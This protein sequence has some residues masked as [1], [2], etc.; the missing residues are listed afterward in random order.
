MAERDEFGAF[1]VGFVVGTLTG[2]VTALLLAPQ[3]GEETRGVIRDKA[4]ELKSKAGSTVEDAYS[5]AEAAAL[6]AR[7]RF[8]EL[9][10]TTKA[11]A[12]EIQHQGQVVLEEQKAKISDVIQTTKKKV[13][14]A[15]KTGETEAS[16]EA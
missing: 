16:A 3:T 7:A 13:E 4:I 15:K 10:N 6:E 8:E 1:L 2:A 11:K 14:T 9:A 5:Q 12:S